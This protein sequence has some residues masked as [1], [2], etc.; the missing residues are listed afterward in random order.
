MPEVRLSPNA[1]FAELLYPG[2]SPVALDAAPASGGVDCMKLP[3]FSVTVSVY[4]IGSGALLELLVSV[5]LYLQH[6][7]VIA[8]NEPYL[9]W[10]FGFVVLNAVSVMIGLAIRRRQIQTQDPLV[11]PPLCPLCREIMTVSQLACP[12]H[13]P[14]PL[15]RE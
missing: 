9:T 11:E 1:L 3:P 12:T 5:G 2:I 6:I 8:I 7:G 14:Y 10:S 13:G 4:G 15:D